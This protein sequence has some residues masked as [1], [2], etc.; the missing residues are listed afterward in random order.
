MKQ[1]A[2]LHDTSR[3]AVHRYRLCEDTVFIVENFSLNLFQR[4]GVI[5]FDRCEAPM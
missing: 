3:E 2:K 4:H 5:L 1:T